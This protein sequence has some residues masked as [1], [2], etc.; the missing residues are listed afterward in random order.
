MSNLLVYYCYYYD[1]DHDAGISGR[2][3]FV[4]QNP[5]HACPFDKN[6]A[7]PCCSP[8]HLERA[9]RSSSVSRGQFRAGLKTHLFTQDYGHLLRTFV[10]QRISLHLHLHLHLLLLS[11]LLRG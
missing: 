9:S 3:I 4:R 11:L 8:S 7:R 1:D 5:R 10:E 2:E 6:T